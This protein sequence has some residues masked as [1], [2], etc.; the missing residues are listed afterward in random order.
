ML[1]GPA[2]KE[3]PK[4]ADKTTVILIIFGTIGYVGSDIASRFFSVV[5]NRLNSAIDYKTNQ[6]DEANGTLGT[7]T[8]ATK[9]DKP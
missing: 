4:F 1:L 9:I 3:Y 8:P 7:P 6:A 2:L 5:N